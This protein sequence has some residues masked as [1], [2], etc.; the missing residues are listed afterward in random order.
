MKAIFHIDV[1]DKCSIWEDHRFTRMRAWTGQQ[2][3]GL[4]WV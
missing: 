4:L 1:V 2:R 3:V